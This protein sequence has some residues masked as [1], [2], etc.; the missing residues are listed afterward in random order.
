MPIMS[1]YS[2]KSVFMLPIKGRTQRA[3]SLCV[4]FFKGAYWIIQQFLVHYHHQYFDSEEER[5]KLLLFLSVKG[6]SDM[7]TFTLC[8]HL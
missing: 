4:P 8:Y 5:L 2:N 7:C 3:T 6:E 1:G